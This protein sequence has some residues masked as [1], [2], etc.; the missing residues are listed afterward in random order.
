MNHSLNP[1]DTMRK[2]IT[3]LAAL[4]LMLGSCTNNAEQT[5]QQ[6]AQEFAQAWCN[7]D[8]LLAVEQRYHQAEQ[9]LWLPGSTMR[10]RKAFVETV[11][12]T[13]SMRAIVYV[14][15]YDQKQ[16]A[17]LYGFLIFEQLQQQSVTPDKARFML[18]LIDW[19]THFLGK[20]GHAEAAKAK[21]DSEARRL[22]PDQQMALYA[23]ITSPTM[24]GLAL[25]ADR[26]QPDA[27]MALIDKQLQALQQ[28]YTAEELHEFQA[29][30]GQ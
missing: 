28:I 6:L 4:A 8:S 23:R 19:S 10:L 15:A 21:I 14:M 20:P 9:A 29:A 3:L 13:D 17:N 7:A 27:D 26:E 30:Y 16:Y 2:T 25:K 12:Q 18:E 22:K 11:S 5:G 1:S 24:L